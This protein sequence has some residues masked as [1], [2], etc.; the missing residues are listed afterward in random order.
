MA[1]SLLGID[2]LRTTGPTLPLEALPVRIERRG[3]GRGSRTRIS[4]SVKSANLHHPS[5]VA[6]RS[7]TR[8]AKTRSQL[9]VQ[10]PDLSGLLSQPLLSRSKLVRSK[11]LEARE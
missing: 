10:P 5:G 3:A 1:P 9:W 8:T 11:R 6:V 2:G 7:F 4:S